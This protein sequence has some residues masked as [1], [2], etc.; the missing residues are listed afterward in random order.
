MMAACDIFRSGA[1]KQLRAHAQVLMP[2]DKSNC[3]YKLSCCHVLWHEKYVLK[4]G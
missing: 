1:V 3:F 4:I 2:A